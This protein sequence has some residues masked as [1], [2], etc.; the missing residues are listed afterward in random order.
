MAAN[1]Y[2]YHTVQ[3]HSNKSVD[4][5]NYAVTTKVTGEVGVYTL[6]AMVLNIH[7]SAVAVEV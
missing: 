7:R 6:L 1:L 4:K 5:S 2:E 3:L